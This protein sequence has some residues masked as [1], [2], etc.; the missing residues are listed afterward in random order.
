MKILTGLLMVLMLLGLVAG[1]Q[2][3]IDGVTYKEVSV[4]SMRLD[5]PTDWQRSEDIEELAGAAEN[6]FGSGSEEYLHFDGYDA[7]EDNVF[8]I[9]MVINVSEMYESEGLDWEDWESML[10][11][12]GMSQEDF[13][14]YLI[15]N[16]VG[17]MVGAGAQVLTQGQTLQH[18]IHGCEAIETEVTLTSAG[19]SSMA[20]VLLVYP[21]NDLGMLCVFGE[22]SAVEKYEDIWQEIRDSVQ[23]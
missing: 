23:F 20:C 12:E 21:T 4:D 3:T 7:P 10:E 2:Q 15:S 13:N 22:E 19:V 16:L 17:G 8:L 18:T 9:L 11:D 6:A 14:S 5:I 1:C